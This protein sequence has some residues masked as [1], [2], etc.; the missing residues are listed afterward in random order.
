MA[1][2][3]STEEYLVSDRATH[4]FDNPAKAATRERN[5]R[6]VVDQAHELWDEER[7]VLR[8]RWC[9]LMG[10][11]GIRTLEMLERARALPHGGFVGVDFDPRI[12]DAAKIRY[13]HHHWICG[14]LF[15]VLRSAELAGVSVVNF[16]AYLAVASGKLAAAGRLLQDLIGRAIQSFGACVVLWNGDLDCS[17][18]QGILPSVA[19]R[20]HARALAEVLQRCAGPRRLLTA[21]LLLPE[22]SEHQVDDGYT[23]EVGAFD[24]YK[25][26]GG[27]HRMALARAVL[28]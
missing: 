22:E 28:R 7:G 26:K 24:I 18:R 23:G 25:G 1:R 16:D 20:E 9:E 14:D 11:S 6:V 21:E 4:S 3:R 17:R 13:P 8:G 10:T 19:L 15:D 12:I 27:G 5:L 2:S